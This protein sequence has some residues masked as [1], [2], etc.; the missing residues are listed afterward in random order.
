M[1]EPAPAPAKS[2]AF[3]AEHLPL[4]QC[5]SCRGP[6]TGAAEGLRCTGCPRTFPLKEGVLQMLPDETRQGGGWGVNLGEDSL[7]KDPEAGGAEKPNYEHGRFEARPSSRRKND[8][9]RFIV[10]WFLS[11]FPAGA[12][13]LDAPCGMGRFSDVALARGAKLVSVDLAFEH[14]AYAAT[15][16]P[17][18]TPLCIQGDLT[19]L[20]L[21]ND[22][23]AAGLVI[24]VTHYFDA[25]TLQRVLTEAGRVAPEL[26]ISYRSAWSPIAWRSA[27]L[28]RLRGR[29]PSPKTNRSLKEILRIADLAGLAM[30]ERPPKSNPLHLVQFVRLRRKP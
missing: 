29:G 24:R 20:P 21:R 23:V 25:E 16:V 22:A 30:V 14:A 8:R 9:E 10:D 2:A 13:V 18:Q 17:G 15:R 3:P 4:L 27:L 5:P 28:R 26:L 11:K 12:P 7:R 1:S 19:A 6:V